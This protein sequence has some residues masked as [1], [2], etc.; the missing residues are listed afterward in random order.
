[1]SFSVQN[2]RASAWVQIRADLEQLQKQITGLVSAAANRSLEC[3][4]N[5]TMGLSRLA[6]DGHG[7][8]LFQTSGTYEKWYCT[9]ATLPQFKCT[10]TW[11]VVG[12]VKTKGIPNCSSWMETVR[13]SNNKILQQSG[14][15]AVAI[16]PVLTGGYD[17]TT[18]ATVTSAHLDGLGQFFADLFRIN[19]QGLAQNAVDRMVT[20]ARIGFAIPSEFRD[21]VKIEEVSFDDDGS[22]RL[23]LV[24]KGTMSLDADQLA[25]ACR[26]GTLQGI[27]SGKWQ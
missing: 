18:S 19:I 17:I 24:A 23:E 20:G 9:Y 21:F 15:L 10:D 3:G 2:D 7:G 12:P 13:T 26:A 6:P 4:D 22:A 27:C 11:I 16:R 14:S 25:E 5:V 8:V 1:M